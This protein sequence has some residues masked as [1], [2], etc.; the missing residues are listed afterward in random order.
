MFRKVFGIFAAILATCG[1][2]AAAK[3]PSDTVSLHE[4][5]AGAQS[6]L[7]EISKLATG[8]GSAGDEQTS[9]KKDQLAQHHHHW[10]N[11]H[12]WHNWNNWRNH[13]HHHHH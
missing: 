2:A 8:T 9:G 5:I 6:K 13:H 4:R 3:P 10:N 1:T 12:N 11:W 7:G